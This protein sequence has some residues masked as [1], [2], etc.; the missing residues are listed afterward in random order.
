M[1]SDFWDIR[2]TE[3]PATSAVPLVPKLLQD[4]A[5]FESHDLGEVLLR[6]G[7]ALTGT[8]QDSSGSPVEGADVDVRDP[9]TDEEFETPGDNTDNS[10][11]FQVL[12][13]S[14]SWELEVGKFADAIFTDSL[15]SESTSL[16]ALNV[17]SLVDRC[18]QESNLPAYK[19]GMS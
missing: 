4:I 9:V 13:P 11:V 14:G 1:I 15:V 6:N 2:F 8:I 18:Y 3:G 10:G 7:Q 16:D 19:R 5:A 12:V 17:M